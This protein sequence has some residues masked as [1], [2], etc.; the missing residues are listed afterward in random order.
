MKKLCNKYTVTRGRGQVSP[1]ATETVS[2]VTRFSAVIT[3]VRLHGR[4]C[5]F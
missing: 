5:S 3:A 2:L 4:I 1:L